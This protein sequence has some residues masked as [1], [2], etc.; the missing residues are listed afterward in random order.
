MDEKPDCIIN[1]V[2]ATNLERNLYLT[3]QV[4]EIDVP[5][6]IALNMMDEV[7]KLGNKIDEKL[8]EERLGIPV[9]KISALKETGL[10][11][12]MKRAYAASLK[13]RAGETVLE[14]SALSHLIGDVKLALKG[15][16]VENPLFHAVKL[17][18]ND[19]IE[20]DMH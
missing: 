19:S 6:V 10:E 9:V 20:A 4:M 13:K 11:E 5:V 7:E 16:G 12:L 8:L 17:V 15:Q 2:D 1:I 14:S 18:E 3:T